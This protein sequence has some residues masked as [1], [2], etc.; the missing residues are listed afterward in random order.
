MSSMSRPKYEYYGE[1]KK[2]IRGY[3]KDRP[4][5]TIMQGIYDTAIARAMEDTL[6]MPDGEERIKV[7]EYVLIKGGSYI[8]ASFRYHYSDSTVTRWVSQFVNLVALYSG[9]L[10]KKESQR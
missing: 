7:V 9:N 1:V 6:R 4:I 5:V 10:E 3:T 8:E 2:R